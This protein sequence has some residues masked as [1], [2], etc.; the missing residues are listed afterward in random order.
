VVPVSG[1]A[2]WRPDPSDSARQRY[3]DGVRWTDWVHSDDGTALVELGAAAAAA[4]PVDVAATPGRGGWQWVCPAPWAARLGFWMMA[5]GGL[6]AIVTA[7]H[8]LTRES[9]VAAVASGYDSS[10]AVVAMGLALL[11]AGAAG[12]WSAVIWVRL[13][14]L[15]AGAG[16]ASTLALVAVAAR[17]GTHAGIAVVLEPAWYD[18]A[19]GA[20]AGLAGAVLVMA[21]P[22]ARGADPAPPVPVAAMGLAAALAWIVIAPLAAVG[23][24][25]GALGPGDSPGAARAARRVGAAVFLLWCAVL[26]GAML[27]VSN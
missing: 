1:P 4:P 10:P 19:L 21:R 20:A 5:C 17:I 24:A 8:A 3:W 25:C 22:A 2:G 15:L 14:V 18:L 7:G 13:G 27:T 26:I 23:G 11:L 6:L 12:A 16:L 9:L